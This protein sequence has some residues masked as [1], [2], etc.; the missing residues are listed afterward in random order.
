MEFLPNPFVGNDLKSHF[1]KLF[2][3]DGILVNILFRNKKN[4]FRMLKNVENLFLQ[5]KAL[6]TNNQ[7][8]EIVENHS[9]YFLN[10]LNVIAF[11]N[12]FTFFLHKK[13]LY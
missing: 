10:S 5:K 2:L 1:Y 8:V 9:K 12:K 6:S 3:E 11:A 4:F 13:Y 7:E